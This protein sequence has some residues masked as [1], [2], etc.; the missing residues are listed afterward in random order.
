M[1]AMKSTNNLLKTIGPGLLFA[2]AAIGVSH[3][4]QSTRAGA[5]YGFFLLWAIFLAHLTKY[6]FFAIGH[7]Y[8]AATGNNL[9]VGY[10]QVGK[11]AFSGALLVSFLSMFTIQA[12]VTLVTAGLA[13]LLFDF[14]QSI[15]TTSGILLGGCVLIL[16]I[17]KYKVLDRSI[18]WI[19]IILTLSTLIAFIAACFHGS[20]IKTDFVVT[21][22]WNLAGFSFL[23]AFMGWMPAP[24]DISIWNS[25]WAE[26]KQKTT[27]Y[28]PTLKEAMFDFHLG[29]T[30]CL[31]LA[32]LFLSLG[33]FVMY[34]TGETFSSSGVVFAKQVVSLY[35]QSLGQW[36]YPI[37]LVAAFSTMLS[38][39][40]TCLDAFPFEKR[41]SSG[42]CGSLIVR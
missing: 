39:T 20:S 15:A 38:T 11:W 4:V 41:Y 33:A 10:W 27:G 8:Q 18:K 25:I 12:A 31:I 1:T 24:L 21:P 42:K 2:G 17:G 7:R 13:S 37:I 5:N 3:L 22:I 14:G 40:L 30:T 34:G 29:F 9:L 23:I 36:S 6:P 32:I 28:R 35:T 16:V 19:I 26:E